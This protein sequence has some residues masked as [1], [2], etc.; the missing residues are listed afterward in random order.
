[1]FEKRN[2]Q[3]GASQ[4]RAEKF[5]SLHI[6]LI[7]ALALLAW[8]FQSV[9]AETVPAKVK[10]GYYENE[11]F[12]EGADAGA[13]RK[14]YAYEYYR[15]LSNYTGWQYEYVYGEYAELYQMFINGEIDLLAGLAKTQDRE[16]IIGYPELSMGSET[17]MM[18]KHVGHPE[19][20]TS[21]DTL[22]GSRIGVLDSAMVEA[23][24]RFLDEHNI[25]AETMVYPNHQSL[26]NAFDTNVID[27]MVVESDGTYKR[28]NAEL[29][30]SFG[31]TEYYL[32]VTA[33]RP[34]LL[35]TL[36]RAQ[37]QL[38][39]EE[40]NYINSLRVKYYSASISSRALSV[41]EKAWL[42]DH[43]SM[44]IGYLKNYLPFS[45]SDQHGNVTGLV[46][47]LL[48]EI[49]REFGVADISLNYSGYDS[50]DEMIAALDSGDIDV[51]FPVGGGL[52][53]S[54]ESG[55]AQ[56]NPVIF[57]TPELVY[58][59]EYKDY[60]TEHF[61][62][63]EKNRMQ[64]Y[65]VKTHFPNAK[66]TSYPSIEDCLH[67]VQDGSAFCTILNG[68]RANEILK[69]RDFHGLSLK[70]LGQR[71]ERCFG[72]RMGNDGLLKLLNR[73]INIIGEDRMDTLAYKYVDGLYHRGFLDVVADY[74]WI[75]TMIAVAAV[76][77]MALF[78][79]R[80]F[81]H[82]RNRMQE[83]EKAGRVLKEKNEE[84]ARRRAELITSNAK[85]A[86]AA[87][88]AD[89]ANQAKTY[90]LS[91]M[92]HDIRTPMNSILS[93][94]EM[95]LRECENEN[96]LMYASHIRAA[97]NTLLGL[98]N[99]ILDFSKMEAGKLDIL[100]VDYEISSLLNDLVNMAKP[101]TEGKGLKLRLNVDCGMPNH[102]HGDEIRI[103]Q[104]VTN[105]LINAVK[106]TKQGEI[107]FTIGYDRLPE[108]QDSIMLN[109]SVKDTGVG[110]RKEDMGKLF[111]AFERIDAANNRNIEG[112]GLGL[113]IT[114]RLLQLMGSKLEVESEYGKGSVFRFSVKQKVIKWEEV[115]DYEA[116]FRRSVAEREKY[117]EKFI[118]PEAAVLVVDDT[119]MNLTVIKSLL[120]RTKL[121]IDTVE[122]GDEGI[123]LATQKRYDIIFL[124]HMMPFKDGIETLHELKETANNPNE[125]TPII[126]LTA[127][128][129]SGM[130]EHYLA[131]GF[132]DYLTKP[133]NPDSLEDT[134]L[135]YL[136]KDKLRPESENTQANA[137]ENSET[138]EEG[139][140]P[141]FMY[142]IDGL[143]VNMG[144]MHCVSSEAYMEI[145]AVFAKAVNTGADVIEGYWNAGDIENTTIKVHSLKSS[146]RT[147]GA[148]ALGNFAE[149]MEKAG[150][151]RDIAALEA[152]IGE[153]LEDY[154][155]L[156]KALAPLIDK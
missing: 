86:L 38:M 117:K 137:G 27:I 6:P 109:F 43:S 115:G 140:I 72:V 138:D 9:Q 139:V 93:M 145:V 8:F 134:I 76:I 66:I 120:K 5:M 129:I 53:F 148:E 91:A 19:I 153:L 144:R 16:K 4:R 71:D 80:E 41:A 37:E 69:N 92:S 128:A 154:R 106:Y 47:E 13:V 74:F 57:S 75:F 29:L 30:Y 108:E 21:F 131:E 130:R 101:C 151:C 17:Y 111:K 31:S 127:N 113:S 55:I 126:C 46:K 97:G 149:K 12:Q 135:R 132:D 147:I 24:Q 152:H 15:K 146:A 95:I 65:Y 121:Q 77:F 96:I 114:Q 2:W 73:G 10:V 116:A 51:A 124:D 107:D 40:P 99:D 62:V 11:I 48:S 59:G 61:A 142:S 68:M 85:L 3:N 28:G 45:D 83:K 44:K 49:M 32:C 64:Y 119:P 56:S 150:K 94:N 60:K 143:D 22:A 100:P 84:L 87:K 82:A 123:A 26:L 104:A 36:N 33:G 90:F 14:G 58:E 81:A 133:I 23:L 118:A 1:M 52:F 42:Q 141:D 78:L 18:V 34:D 102:L 20:T 105:I 125:K 70:L 156:G 89:S 25:K 50:Y 54:E 103:K 88:E 112:T 155:N 63:N 35:D 7:C 67:A 98:I 136:P 39:V 79:A 122:S 110:I